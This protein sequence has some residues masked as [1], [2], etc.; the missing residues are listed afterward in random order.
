M[1]K[2]KQVPKNTKPTSTPDNNRFLQAF[3]N[4]MISER[5]QEDMRETVS[6]KYQVRQ[7][8]SV[9]FGYLKFAYETFYVESQP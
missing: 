3:Q 1:T 6:P 2:L 5:S 8:M 9:K 7:K 4:L